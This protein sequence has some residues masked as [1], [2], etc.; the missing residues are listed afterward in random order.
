[1]ELVVIVF[2]NDKRLNRDEAVEPRSSN[3]RTWKSGSVVVSVMTRDDAG[4]DADEPWI[5]SCDTHGE[6]LACPTKRS[7]ESAA[8]NRDWCSGCQSR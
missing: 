7:A 5:A 4:V 1:M 8:R 2:L 6:M 3:G